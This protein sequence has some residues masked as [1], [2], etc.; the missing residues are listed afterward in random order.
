MGGVGL[1]GLLWVE[2]GWYGVAWKVVGVACY[3][4]IDMQCSVM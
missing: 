4:V 1:L 2:L 3:H